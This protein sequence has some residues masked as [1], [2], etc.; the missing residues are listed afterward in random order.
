VTRRR[1]G[2]TCPITIICLLTAAAIGADALAAAPPLRGANARAHIRE[3]AGTLAPDL[4]I[5]D[6]DERR[7]KRDVRAIHRE[8]RRRAA[9][10]YIGE[11]LLSRDSSLA[12]WPERRARPIRVWI[13]P[14][15]NL[16]DWTASYIDEVHAAFDEWDTLDLS[17][18]FIYVTDSRDAE[19][20]V[21]WINSFQERIS[22]RT[23][24]TRDDDWWITDA[25]IELAVHHHQGGVLDEDAMHALALHEIGHLLGL[26]H[27]IDVRSIMAP[28][29]RVR[30]LSEAD[31]ATVRL[32][33]SLP[34][35][36]VR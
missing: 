28:K 27:T 18:S 21:T 5:F 13:Q 1:I 26:D 35:G 17:V 22:G 8:L 29:V 30:T 32:L 36:G 12:R 3:A 16:P 10:T 25:S 20:R 6:G 33:Y 9:G 2:L 14:S 19:A 24:W 4:G 23:T 31:K 34:P 11:M 7:P 15:S